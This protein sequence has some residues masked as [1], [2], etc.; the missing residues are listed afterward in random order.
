MAADR[1]ARLRARFEGAREARVADIEA[2]LRACGWRQRGGKGSHRAW[3]KEGKR[4]LVVP[5]HGGR[6]RGYVIGQVLEATSDD[7]TEAGF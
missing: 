6:V 7:E 5:V 2:Y 1:R 3:V 4:T